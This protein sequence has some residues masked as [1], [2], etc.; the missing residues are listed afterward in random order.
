MLDNFSYSSNS[1]LSL[2]GMG[3][4]AS[5]AVISSTTR[6]KRMKR[7]LFSA[8]G[9]S[10]LLSMNSCESNRDRQVQSEQDG[11]ELEGKGPSSSSAPTDSSGLT[12]NLDRPSNPDSANEMG[13]TTVNPS[14][15]QY[16][17][18]SGTIRGDQRTSTTGD[19]AAFLQEVAVGNLVEIRSSEMAKQQSTNAEIR[20]FADMMIADHQKNLNELKP[21]AQRN[22]VVLPNELSPDKKREVVQLRSM[23]GGAFDR[24]Y[25]DLQLK[26]HQQTV[27][28]FET[29][30][31][32]LG[33]TDVR[34]FVDKSLPVLR[35]HLQKVSALHDKMGKVNH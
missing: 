5:T 14:T 8:I 12:N 9:L 29:I 22:N 19:A 20:R 26:S 16:S 21:L 34:A 35:N 17:G 23:T 11:R 15:G 7:S 2:H 10:L 30:G 24:A 31:Q 4:S 28:K 33:D 32:S 13:S 1:S 3:L 18:D 27:A 6:Y 25:V